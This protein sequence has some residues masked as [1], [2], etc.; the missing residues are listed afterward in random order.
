MKRLLAVFAG[1]VCIVSCAA[2]EQG[3]GAP[4]PPMPHDLRPHFN[5]VF[6]A[7]RI[8]DPLQR[9]LAYPDLPGNAWPEGAVRAYCERM[10]RQGALPLDEFEEMLGR[11]DG[12]ATIE[13]RLSALLDAHF[14]DPAQLD[15]I[16]EFFFQFDADERSGQLATRWLRAS[17]DSPFA[18]TALAHHRTSMAWAARGTAFIKDTSAH[19]LRRMNQLLL[20]AIPLLQDALARQPKLTPA[21]LELAELGRSSFDELQWPA[22]DHCEKLKADSYYISR[23]M[24]FAAL[25]KWGGSG[26]AID[27]VLG[28]VRRHAPDNPVLHVLVARAQ[29]E[30]AWEEG[31]ARID[32][33]LAAAR[34]APEADVLYDAALNAE[35]WE[36]VL[37]Y[38]Q[39][40]RFRPHSQEGRHARYVGMWHAGQWDQ[41]EVDLEWLA[42]NFPGEHEY[43]DTYATVLLRQQRRRE[44]IPHLRAALALPGARPV[45]E[46]WLCGELADAPDTAASDEVAECT[47]K[48]LAARPEYLGAWHWRASHFIAR[49]NFDALARLRA[50]LDGAQLDA[51]QQQR[52]LFIRYVSQYLED[53]P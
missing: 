9:C 17:P 29:A 21:C 44:A 46:E 14:N 30:R 6:E 7:E 35:G 49:R 31:A 37:Q 43:A 23:E 41:M 26:E 38:T 36:Q 4:L 16:H 45:L 2:A 39:L 1:W 22:L 5:A 13:A 20:A 40:L 15:L 25:P 48:L 3:Q 8:A 12:A 42:R 24:L 11:P 51:P 32:E 52:D 50:E 34:T 10:V 19:Q 53:S 28:H 47:R 18:M 33:L 27:V